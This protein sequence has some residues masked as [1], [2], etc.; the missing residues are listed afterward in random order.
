MPSCMELALAR[1]PRELV[2]L[3]REIGLAAQMAEDDPSWAFVAASVQL[4]PEHLQRVVAS[5]VAQ[6]RR[7]ERWRACIPVSGVLVSASLLFGM[8]VWAG[9]HGWLDYMR[10]DLAEVEQRL[11]AAQATAPPAWFVRWG[12]SAD[13]KAVGILK[14][15]S[16]SDVEVYECAASRT[17]AVCIAASSR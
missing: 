11:A 14:G 1:L 15:V 10:S 12:E 3:A 16:V 5:G 8:G 7:H 4:S 2:H 17:R 6:A 9:V 13:G